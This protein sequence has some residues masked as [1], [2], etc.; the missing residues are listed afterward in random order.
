MQTSFKKSKALSSD[1]LQTP[2][3]MN[4]WPSRGILPL[5]NFSMT[6]HLRRIET[7][8]LPIYHH[9]PKFRYGKMELVNTL[10]RWN[11]LCWKLY[12]IELESNVFTQ[13]KKTFECTVYVTNSK[14]FMPIITPQHGHACNLRSECLTCTF[15]ES[16]CSTRLS[17]AQVPVFASSSVLDRDSLNMVQ[18]LKFRHV[19]WNNFYLKEIG[20]Y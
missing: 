3:D 8:T 12:W 1:S 13:T 10:C 19:L 18:I 2:V 17:W 14:R 5:F 20:S 16:C 11:I 4:M 7:Y 15:R 6:G 9:C